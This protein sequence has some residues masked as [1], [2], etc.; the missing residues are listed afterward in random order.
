M[1]LDI[2]FSSR[3]AKFS[4]G[5][6]KADKA[7]IACCTMLD[8]GIVPTPMMVCGAL[9]LPIAG[10]GTAVAFN[11]LIVGM[12]WIDLV[13]GWVDVY[14][15]MA[16]GVILSAAGVSFGN[17]AS[18]LGVNPIP[19]V[20]AN[21]G[22]MVR[23][24]GQLGA[25]YHGDAQLGYSPVQGPLGGGGVTVTRD[26]ASGDVTLQATR[27]GQLGG[28][29]GVQQSDQLIYHAAD[30]SIEE[31][32]SVTGTT[33]GGGQAERGRTRTNGGEW[34]QMDSSGDSDS[35]PSLPWSEGTEVPFL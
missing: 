31:R 12:H 4:A 29:A 3:K 21:A 18:G 15:S 23:L 9:S 34:Q 7:A 8:L 33:I 35:G 20:G 1:A 14:L 17:I 30:G 28:L 13:A 25:D 19:D 11:S 16:Q 2:A 26:G 27:G 6:V 10:T 5:E 32:Q 24:M 22:G